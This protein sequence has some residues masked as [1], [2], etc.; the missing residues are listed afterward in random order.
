MASIKQL[1]ERR[2]KITVSN[3]YRPDGRKISK[4]KTIH[5]PPGSSSCLMLAIFRTLPWFAAVFLAQP[6][7]PISLSQ[8]EPRLRRSR[9]PRRSF[10]RRFSPP[11]AAAFPR[12]PHLH[13][14]VS[15]RQPAQPRRGSGGQAADR[16]HAIPPGQCRRTD[17]HK[18]CDPL[19]GYQQAEVR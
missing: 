2:Y 19:E 5:V 15:L 12:R 16:Y 17:H 1:D 14:V 9:P 13:P 18:Q 8:P 7:H 3:G 4:A 11:C 6:A 10:R